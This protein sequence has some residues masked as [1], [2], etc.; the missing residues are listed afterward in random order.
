MRYPDSVTGQGSRLLPKLLGSYKSELHTVIDALCQTPFDC[1]ED[2]G[3]AEGYYAVGFAM[4]CPSARLQGHDLNMAALEHCRELACANGVAQRVTLGGAITTADLL[5]L[6]H[7]DLVL[8]VCDCEGFEKHFFTPESALALRSAHVLVEM[9]DC[10]DLQ[11]STLL[12]HAFAVT[13]DVEV[14]SSVPDLFKPRTS[15]WP[16]LASFDLQIRFQILN[17][18]RPDIMELSVFSPKL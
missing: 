9:H 4:R 8:V 16:E 3:C 1:I 5:Q 12:V 15:M 7:Q 18:D 14:I 11:I 10:F 6:S 2:I 17:E 13:H